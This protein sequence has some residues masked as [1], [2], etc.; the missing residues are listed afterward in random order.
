MHARVKPV[1]LVVYELGGLSDSLSAR[2]LE[3]VLARTGGVSAAVVNH[4]AKLM[5]LSFYEDQ[6]S[7]SALRRLASQQ[8]QYQVRIPNYGAIEASGPQ[9]PVPMSYIQTFER[10]KYAFCIR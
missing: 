3:Q 5:S 6:I 10:I 2:Q 4:H 7:E 1:R 9:C 8:G